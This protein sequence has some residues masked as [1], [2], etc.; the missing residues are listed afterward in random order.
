MNELISLIIP[1]YNVEAYIDEC[2]RSV[3]AQSYPDLDIILINDGSTDGSLEVLKKWGA[4][5]ERI[6]VIDKENEGVSAARNLGVT[7]AKGEVIGFIDPDDWIDERYVEK[8]FSKMQETGA[9]FVEC[10]LWRYDNRSGH[11][12]YRSCGM[13]MGKRFSREEHMKYGPT[14]SYKSLS[15]KELWLRYGIKFPSCSFE[16]P[17]IY[18]LILALSN[19][20]ENVEEALYYYR[21]FRENSLIETGYRRKDGKAND[22]LG[23]EAMEFLLSEF[24]RC[25]IYEKYEK[26]LEGVIKYRLSDILAMQFHRRT[27]E[28]FDTLRRNYENFCRQTFPD[29]HNERY[30]TFGGYNLNR[31]LSHMDLLNDPYCRFNFSSVIA[32]S[33]RKQDLPIPEHANRYRKL[34]LE[35]EFDHSYYDILEEVHPKYLF[36]DLIEERCDVLKI[37]DFYLTESDALNT[38][39]NRN[40]IVGITVPRESAECTSLFCGCFDLFIR[41]TKRIVPDLQII[42]VLNYLSER[43]G[44]LTSQVYFDDIAHIREINIIL[45]Q[46]YAYIRDHHPDIMMIPVKDVPEYF[47]DRKYE[48][49]AIPSHLNEAVNRKIAERIEEVL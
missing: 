18:S 41:N 19:K 16:S 13:V 7:L 2:M 6:R 24:K 47:T 36:M 12:I 8:L 4:A 39:K 15:R 3:V 22:T 29:S 32:L 23:I 20:V 43:K 21:R 27:R 11:K 48:Y 1:V 5:D 35:R 9:E 33:G 49:G 42:I 14:A 38:M 44:D 28:E 10:D 26:V 46:Y 40:E 31:I 17:A 37:N 34:M 30:I 25:G 45:S